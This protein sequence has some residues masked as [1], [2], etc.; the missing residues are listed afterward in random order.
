MK[1]SA[2]SVLVKLRFL[3]FQVNLKVAGKAS[4]YLTF[5]CW[6]AFLEGRNIF[7]FSANSLVVSGNTD[8]LTSSHSIT[9][10][11]RA[12]RST[13]S[14]AVIRSPVS[15]H[16]AWGPIFDE[17]SQFRTPPPCRSLDLHSELSSLISLGFRSSRTSFSAPQAL[18]CSS[19]YGFQASEHIL[20]MLLSFSL[21]SLTVVSPS[22]TSSKC[23][24]RPTASSI[25]TCIHR[26]I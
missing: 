8:S 18:R 15:A 13:F 5:S 23:E 9:C 20:T 26:I 25:L 16:L 12:A 10:L 17:P 14:H 1:H 19:C 4:V 2:S 21:A 7:L 22:V 6:S 24:I 11:S 3:P